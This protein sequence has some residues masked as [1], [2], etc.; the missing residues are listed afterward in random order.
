MPT[1][2]PSVNSDGTV[3]YGDVTFDPASA[4]TFFMGL[5]SGLQ[6]NSDTFGKCFYITTDT[7][8][9][10]DYFQADFTTVFDTYNFYQLFVYD[11]THFTG[12]MLAVYE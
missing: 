11:T 2:K 3:T 4:K 8:G 10:V 6:F 12:N 1:N 5:V 9:F 7:L